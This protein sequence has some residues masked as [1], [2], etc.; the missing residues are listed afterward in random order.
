VNSAG[1]AAREAVDHFTRQAT[2][3]AEHVAPRFA[4]THDYLARHAQTMEPGSVADVCCGDG[5]LAPRLPG[6][7]V[8]G[9]DRSAALLRLARAAA[10][11]APL[12]QADARALPLPDDRFDLVVCNLALM[13]TGDPPATLAELVRICAPGGQI[14][15]SS[16]GGVRTP[17]S[18][19][20]LPNPRIRALLLATPDV[21]VTSQCTLRAVH[22]LPGRGALALLLQGEVGTSAAARH[23]FAPT[24]DRTPLELEFGFEMFHLSVARSVRAGRAAR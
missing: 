8:V 18:A 2:A 13:L 3:Y 16:L 19:S 21:S 10:P 14:V 20:P 24:D 7:P 5:R 12:V 23:P 6:T 11:T 4:V 15:V 17:R 1:V 22:V 9:V